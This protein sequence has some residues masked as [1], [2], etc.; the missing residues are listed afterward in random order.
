MKSH[1]G[2]N[3]QA[4]LIGL[5]LISIIVL[6]ILTNAS[7]AGQPQ[8]PQW[9]GPH[10][11]GHSSETGLPVRW[12][13]SAVVWKTPLKGNGQSSP[14]IWNDRI[15]LTSALEKGKKRLV[16]CLSAKDGKIL[17][18]K[19][20]WSGKPE[21]AHKL[22]GWAS[23]TCVTDGERV[24]ASFGKAGLH[25][26]TVDGEHLWSKELG[27]FLSKNKRGTAASL[28]LTDDMVIFNGDS[29][30][31]PYLFGIDKL[32]GKTMWKTKRPAT[33]GY[34][35][36]IIIDTGK[37]KEIVLNG[38]Y[39]VAGY[40][41]KTGDELWKCKSFIGR[42]E[43]VP[44]FADGILFVVNGQAKDVYAVRPGGKGDVTKT[45]MVWHTPRRSGRDQPSPIVVNGFLVVSNIAGLATCYDVTDGKPLWTARISNDKIYS[46]PVAAEGKVY[47]LNEAGETIVLEPGKEKK[48]VAQNQVTKTDAELFRASPIPYRGHF[49]LRSQTQLYCVRNKSE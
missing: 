46:S 8:W 22:N 25:C 39:F 15:F 37:R 35:S 26:Y 42:G 6:T 43:P 27:E 31:D 9:R 18:E 40:D 47:F 34:S 30:S 3:R 13:P 41:P 2:M 33:E 1:M 5:P 20:A 44:A 14:V 23:S 7:L 10:G 28:V 48:I 36:P 45:H 21:P 32:S 4:W 11:T 19:E 24:Y 29:E 17:W 49:F 38:H 16:M 12:D